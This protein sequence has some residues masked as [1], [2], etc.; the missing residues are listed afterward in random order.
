[1]RF[2]LACPVVSLAEFDYCLPDARIAQVPVEPRDSAGL[3]VDNGAE[4]APDD[5]LVR[6]LATLLRPDDLVVLNDTRVIPARLH[7]QRASGAA[8]EV[9]LLER[10]GGRRWEALVR[11]SRKV[12]TNEIL[13][14]GSLMVE[15]GEACEATGTRFVTVMHDDPLAALAEHGT[16]PLPPYI[17][18]ALHDPERYQT[19]YARRPGAAAAPTAGLHFTTELL[20]QVAA[21]T[22][23]VARVELVVGLDTFRPL[24]VEH[25]DDH[26]MHS[27]AFSVDE[28]VLERCHAA[29]AAGGRVVAVGTTTVRALE[30]AAA[31]LRDRTDLFIR[32]PFEWQLVD[33]LLTN[34]HLPR[35][36]LLVMIDAFVGPRWRELYEHALAK[37]YRFL[38]F[39]DAMLL[40]RSQP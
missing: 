12:R 38:S 37:D 7:L 6:D 26:R 13:T 36:S 4:A 28:S 25:L 34:F 33:M 16:V 40:E 31:G 23:G 19:V 24:A 15:V 17:T 39:G 5:R 11:G 18:T 35:S 8:I 10:V 2:P 29:R 9:L 32:A 20:A 14:S 21:A 3:L 1:V 27:E 30:S 22:R